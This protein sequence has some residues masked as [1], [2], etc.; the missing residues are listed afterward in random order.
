MFTAHSTERISPEDQTSEIFYRD[1]FLAEKSFTKVERIVEAIDKTI[2]PRIAGSQPS[3]TNPGTNNVVIRKTIALTIKMNNPSVKIV[4]GSVRRSKTG[5][6]NV[7]IMP[8]TTAA[9]RADVNVSTLIP[10]TT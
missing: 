2:A 7:L 9:R 4:R 5:L 1:Y 8:K 3:T 10:G 6:I